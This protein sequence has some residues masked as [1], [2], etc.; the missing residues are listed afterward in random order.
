MNFSAFK[1]RKTSIFVG[2]LIFQILFFLFLL[3]GTLFIATFV[4]INPSLFLE[5]F[6]FFIDNSSDIYDPAIWLFPFMFY[7]SYAL[8]IIVILVVN[9][10]VLLAK[11]NSTMSEKIRKRKFVNR[12]VERMEW[13]DNITGWRKS[14]RLVLLF[15]MSIFTVIILAM[16]FVEIGLLFSPMN[17]FYFTFYLS[18]LLVW[19]VLGIKEENIKTCYVFIIG[20]SINLILHVSAVIIAGD[21]QLLP[22]SLSYQIIALCVL[23]VKLIR[24]NIRIN[25]EGEIT[26]R[27]RKKIQE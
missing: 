20:L 19:L 7:I 11:K 1:K 18:L 27:S 12:I 13:Q 24:S 14:I 10:F 17:T 22:I 23:I 4:L 16:G 3:F 15:S 2:V 6:S 26:L 8:T 25:G 21:E 5:K 9:I